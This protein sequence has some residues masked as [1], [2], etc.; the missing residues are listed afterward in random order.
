MRPVRLAMQAFGPFAGRETVDF[1]E[2]VE[3]GLF[4][5]Y[6]QTGSGKSTIFSAMTFALFGQAAKAEQDTPSLRSDSADAD[7]ITEVELVFDIGDKR[8]VARR[9]PEQRRPKQ[10]GAGETRDA[11]EAWLFDATGMAL[12]EITP[13]QPGKVIAEKKVGPVGRAIENLLGYGAEQFRQIVLLPQGRFEAFLAADTKARLGILR[14][15]F[16]V[17]LYR[18]LAAKM[19]IDAEA[20]ERQFREERAIF[21]RRLN[22]E[23]FESLDALKA[24]IKN[25]YSIH[26]TLQEAESVQREKL[27]NAQ[28]ALD[29][30]RMIDG[31]FQIAERA[32][33]ELA[34]LQTQSPDVDA[35]AGRLRAAERVRM[36]LDT[37][38]QAIDAGQELVAAQTA[39]S[40]TQQRMAIAA[41]IAEA[42][43]AAHQAEEAR[44]S[45]I[46]RMRREVEA[47]E[48][49]QANLAKSAEVSA[50]AEE[51]NNK[52]NTARQVFQDS[53][54][55]VTKLTQQRLKQQE[56]LKTARRTDAERQG[57]Q[58]RLVALDAAVKLGEAME[59]AERDL[60]N[61]DSQIEGLTA[62][63]RSAT[64]AA[65]NA[66]AAYD[67]AERQLS[68]AQ[69]LHLANKLQPGEACPVCGSTDHPAPAT[70]DLQHTG[71]DTVFRETKETWER[72][73]ADEREAHAHLVSARGVLRERQERLSALMRPDR[74]LNDLLIEAKTTSTALQ[75]L[76]PA[77]N[78]QAAEAQLELL[79]N[80]L[81][82]E[83]TLRE[84]CR[85]T[86]QQAETEVTAVRTRLDAMRSEIPEQ[87]RDSHI[88]AATI[89]AQ[90]QALQQREITRRAVA[91]AATGRREDA[92]TARKELKADEALLTDRQ[93]RLARFRN[94]FASRLTTAGLTEDTFQTLKPTV[95]TIDH[96][97][98]TV[99]NY[100]RS[101]HTATDAAR[102][103]NEAIAGQERP[104]IAPFLEVLQLADEALQV[105]Q[106]RRAEAAAR[107]DQLNKLHSE[108]ADTIR[109]L[110]QAEQ[111][112]GPLRELAALFD[113]RN[114]LNLDLETF[115]I[116]AMFDQVLVAAN[117]RLDPM[118]GGRYSLDRAIDGGGRGRRGL[119][120]QVHDIYTG[121]P[122]STTT[123][124]GGESF[125]AALAL[126]LGLADVV[127]SAS[128]KVR[129]DTI[130]IDEG[131]GS[132]DTENG[133]GTLDQVLQA[134]NALVRHNRA[135][136]L[137]SHV[138]LVQEAIPNGFYIRKDLSGSRVEHRGMI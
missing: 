123:L 127:E 131:F 65:S 46:E 138:P 90:Q 26:T 66:K 10:R 87:L 50:M 42:A 84:A 16:D 34:A 62:A 113:S 52:L 27:K 111:E 35:L 14:D 94:E 106:S 54:D 85:I 107:V 18:R 8:Y 118:S 108:L 2:A 23:G 136:G 39:H 103:A 137:I 36:L 38:Q 7:L 128:G 78:I 117:Q 51:A 19:K 126:A 37:E 32:A 86:L 83:E 116:G 40:G 56:A 82:V 68:E 21:A 13:D 44:A 58:A 125:I 92:I 74:P 63:H 104:D 70:S 77:I 81:S 129:L 30:A 64:E 105:A 102:K 41:Q 5:I 80:E 31:L 99:E 73:Q 120:I 4:G 55:R 22:G 57:A 6:G 69:A 20:A 109:R 115:A 75:A 45:E 121:K 43:A 91:E 96:D 12:D 132:L 130:F 59:K 28:I 61:S 112:S 24:G 3:A 124:S 133:A 88:L 60:A 114:P 1:R 33:G 134:L 67:H 135:V 101:L 53:L 89:Q 79:E 49:H 71:L 47:L 98:E 95:A 100:R 29:N 15:L 110:E 93:A 25:A 122:R 97:R 72:L 9:R 11:H 48:R 119:G 17:S 76:G